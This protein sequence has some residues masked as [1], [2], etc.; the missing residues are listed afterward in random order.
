MRHPLAFLYLTLAIII[1]GCTKVKSNVALVHVLSHNDY[2]QNRPLFDALDANINC[3][4]VDIA[5][6]NNQLYVTH[7]IED[8]QEENTFSTLYLN[9][10]R[11]MI[12]KKGFVN[13]QDTPFIL[14]INTKTGGET[15]NKINEA[16]EKNSDII[17]SFT[18][19]AKTKRPI[20]VI[21]GG[22]DAISN[23]NRFMVAEGNLET[24]TSFKANEFYMVNL[25]WGKYFNWKGKE[26]MPYE[27]KIKLRMMV[28]DIHEQGRILRFWDNPDITSV[29]GE[30]FWKTVLN[31]GVDMLSTDAPKEIKIFFDKY[32]SSM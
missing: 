10:L 15:I 3:V 11:K 5:Y 18:K 31:E 26:A 7:A 22:P 19:N 24:S 6:V 25:R 23:T 14:Y 16:L 32:N 21:A 13:K 29:D 12:E 30:N 9:P 17:S 8:I 1:V 2:A 4:E 28:N 20:F 27:E